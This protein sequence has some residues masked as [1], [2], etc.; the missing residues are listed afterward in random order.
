MNPDD[1]P[2]PD[3]TYQ[4]CVE[5]CRRLGIEPPTQE[6]ASTSSRANGTLYFS[7]GVSRR[8]RST[9]YLCLSDHGVSDPPCIRRYS[10]SPMISHSAYR[11]SSSLRSA[12]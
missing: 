8:R 11:R 6:R 3:E 9:S 4:R 12:T 10:G 5:T 1:L 7:A 2:D